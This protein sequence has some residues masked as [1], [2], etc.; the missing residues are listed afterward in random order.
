MLLIGTELCHGILIGINVTGVALIY[1]KQYNNG[2]IVQ[3]RDHEMSINHRVQGYENSMQNV[4][5]AS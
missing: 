2:I 1:L 5:S 4:S 3:K